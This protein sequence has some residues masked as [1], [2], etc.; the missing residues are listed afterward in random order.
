MKHRI[1]ALACAVLMAAPL[2][3]LAADESPYSWE[4]TAVSDYVFRGA[5]QTEED[6]TVQAGFTY[7]TAPGI[8]AGVWASGV[9]FGTDKPDYEVDAMIGWNG[10]LSEQV[11]FDIA[12]N[13]Y[14]YPSAGSNNYNE[15][16]TTTTFAETYSATVAYSNDVWNTDSDGWYFAV[17]GEWELPQEFSLNAGLGYSTFDD[18]V[19]ENYADWSL[20]V[21]RAFGPATIGL[22]YHGTDSDGEYNFGE[23]AD[24]RIVLSVSFGN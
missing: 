8:Y 19:A 20:G 12:L 13:R 14:M 23:L 3:A 4:V 22:T 5:S 21:S 24:D 7:T 2:S 9:D 17:G 11:N 15:L 1:T 6:P 10:D 16:I 18:E